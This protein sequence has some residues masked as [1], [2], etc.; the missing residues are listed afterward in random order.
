MNIG[1]LEYVV[2]GFEDGQFESLVLPEL[3]AIQQSG[4]LRVADMLF[5][6]KAA[7]GTIAMQEVNELDEEV[8]AAYADIADDIAGLF[9][10][11]DIDRLI[12]EIPPGTWAVLV[13]LE[14]TWT[15]QLANAV[16][17]AGGALI[18]GGMVAP[19]ALKK[20]GQELEAAKEKE[21]NHA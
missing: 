11:E 18:S 12:G 19:E 9:T 8:Q 14:H 17:Q 7:D 6:S 13:L 21:E 4:L 16:R 5:V 15:L 2:L 20:V 1:P 3:N 10:A